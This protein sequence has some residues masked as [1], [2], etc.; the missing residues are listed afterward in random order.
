MKQF[1]LIND[2]VRR[3]AAKFCMEAPEGWTVVFREPIKSRGQ[4]NV[5]HDMIGDIAK[6]CDVMGEKMGEEDWKRLLIDGFE[7]Y[8]RELGTPL[9]HGGRIVPSLDGTGFVQL[10]AQS[11][12]FRKREASCFI[13]FLG[14]FGAERGVRWSVQDGR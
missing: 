4:E 13:E 9:T 10:G 7:R 6:Q 5:Y 2:A 11:R 3:N 1:R 14:A 8:M 12:K